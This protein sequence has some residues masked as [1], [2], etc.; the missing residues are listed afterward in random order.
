MSDEALI[1]RLPNVNIFCRVSPEQKLRVLLA[2]KRTGQTVGFLGDG[3]NDAPALHSADVAISVDSGADVAKAAAEIILLDKDLDVLHAGVIE[4][5]RAVINVDKYILMASSA[6]FGNIIS[7]ALAGMFLPF[8][9]LLP[10]QVLLTNLLYDVAQTGLPF[11]RVDR[12]VIER[13]VHW[14]IRF[15]ERFM[16]VM[17]PVSTVFDMVTFAVLIFVFHA[18]EMLFRTGWFIESL[19]TQLLMIFTIRTRHHLFA[20]RPH[21]LVAALAIGMSALTVALPFLPIGAWFGFVMPPPLYFGFLVVAVAGFLIM[22]E[23]VKRLFY[24]YVIGTSPRIPR[25]GHQG[26]N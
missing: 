14:D 19:V 6:N 16:L 15:I 3:I 4:G 24:A 17:G 13:P 23:G 8:L 11:D 10:I 26:S 25:S 18:D 9:P 1:G 20:S 2:L 21:V 5:R 22:I 7:M 12:N